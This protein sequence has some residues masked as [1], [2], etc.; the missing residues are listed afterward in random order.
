MSAPPRIISLC[1]VSLILTVSSALAASDEGGF[2]HSS[3]ALNLSINGMKFEDMDA[4]GFRSEGEPGLPGWTIRLKRNGTE[5]LNTTTDNVGQYSFGDLLPGRY[6]VSEDSISGWN[7]TAPGGGSY[8]VTLTDKPAYNLDF[9]NF[10]AKNVSA[11]P[12][13]RR[14]PVMRPTPEEARRWTEQYKAAPEAYLSP[15]L[16][17]ELALAPGTTFSL[18]DYMPYIP[19]ERDQ[20]YCG[21]CWA[22]AGTGAMEID[23][24]FKN[25]VED[26]LSI[27]YLNSNFHG[28]SGS[29]WACCGGWL[30][31]V[32]D[33]YSST[34]LAVPWSNSNAHWQDGSRF[35]EAHS[36]S[37]PAAS[38][39]TSPSYALTSVQSQVVPT[40][41]VGKEAA[42]ANIKNVLQQGKAV[43]FGFFLPNSA[44]WTDFTTFWD[45][46]AE[47]AVWQPD[48]A[49]GENY[50]YANGVGH[51][52]LCVG[53]DDTDPN[54]RYWIILN[55]W[56]APANRPNGLFR[57]NMDMNYD[58]RYPNYGFAFYWMT[59]GI[60]Y[61]SG[62]NNPPDT[63]SIPSGPSSG[64]GG[65]PYSY[66]TSSSDPDGDSV[67]YT[68]DWG[69]ETTSVTELVKSGAG[70][71]ASHSWNAAG[72]YEIKAMA[73]DS[74]GHSSD[75][76]PSAMVS[77]GGLNRP[78]AAPSL[79]T[80]PT[81][82]Y[83]WV[84]YVYTTSAT[85]PDGDLLSYTFDWGDGTS[86]KVDQIESD[87]SAS[88]SHAWSSAG[89]YYVK[90]SAEDG[91]G[92]ASPWSS[93]LMVRISA[94]RLPATP[95]IPTGPAT[96]INGASY[97][98]TTSAT[99]PDRDKV[100]YTFDWDDGTSSVTGL[101][102]SGSKASAAHIWSGTGDYQVK[103]RA[104]DSKGG[105]SP[106][107]GVL[108][109]AIA[110]NKPPNVPAVPSGPTSGRARTSYSY[111]TSATD[112]EGD[113]VKYAFDW[114]DGASSETPLVGSGTSSSASH[115]W[116]WVGTYY[117]K[118]RT[119]DSKGT[120]SDWSSS[121]TV[122]IST[123]GLNN[124]PI[125][126]SKPSGPSLGRTGVIYRYRTYATDP[127]G[128]ELF[129][130]IDWGDG[131]ASEAGPIRAG[132]SIEARHSWVAPGTYAVRAMARD[133]KGDSSDWSMP[134]TVTIA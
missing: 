38:I 102:S 111:S 43:W 54:N 125:R 76:S 66:T 53:Y 55:S 75:W 21:N 27:Q 71:S 15:G 3:D 36:T 18:L 26:R 132:R 58:C 92:G 37:V 25:G 97:S 41:G 98:Y 103:A 107:S 8:L 124:P 123:T 14:Y 29:S 45:G 22:W 16:Q 79:P 65:T 120:P 57:M 24:A 50:N 48:S 106:W 81:A 10:R 12:F 105:L 86:S 30:D 109:V 116:R 64:Y 33:F 85:D 1:L 47:E 70:A 127:N 118:A 17:A 82:G 74:R 99:D 32:A 31:D 62:P 128:D 104:T 68:F 110:T 77:I 5:L 112:P 133:D 113:K 4:N 91:K 78:P 35:C 63:P 119:I 28:G 87:S 122:R 44:A 7:Q 131:S 49:C 9:G 134:A 126:P 60:A 40:Q 100:K 59:L 61:P 42:I 52:V 95:A 51:A 20:G 83:A 72:D 56:G 39:S 93:L 80:G 129:Y 108:K 130:T 69:D 19:A 73:T 117:V 94:N 34:G 23:N 88:A 90:V 13:S 84:S 115:S 2:A 11:V 46:E 67:K 114:G 6:E 121:L 101:V 89:T 96:G